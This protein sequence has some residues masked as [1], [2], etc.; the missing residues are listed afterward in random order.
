MSTLET[1]L[2]GCRSQPKVVDVTAEEPTAVMMAQITS[3]YSF[4]QTP[5]LFKFVVESDNNTNQDINI[6]VPWE[7]WS[8]IPYAPVDQ[9]LLAANR[10]DVTGKPELF[11]LRPDIVDSVCLQGHEIDPIKTPTAELTALLSKLKQIN[12]VEDVQAYAIVDPD[13]LKFAGCTSAVYVVC[14][15]KDLAGARID[16][17]NNLADQLEDR[18]EVIVPQAVYQDTTRHEDVVRVANESINKS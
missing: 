8:T 1:F 5:T 15:I 16:A 4:A 13:M 18:Y 9:L 10:F 2:S 11:F 14:D 6:I 7:I 12:N 17:L 3:S